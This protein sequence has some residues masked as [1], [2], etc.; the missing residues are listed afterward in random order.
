MIISCE[1]VPG[2]FCM[3]CMKLYV[4]NFSLSQVFVIAYQKQFCTV[5]SNVKFHTE[6]RLI[7]ACCLCVFMS[8]KMTTQTCELEPQC[9]PG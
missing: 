3:F 6:V 2:K 9:I 1:I 5:S 8:N 7:C 4:F